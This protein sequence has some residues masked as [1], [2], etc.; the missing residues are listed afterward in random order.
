[1][2]RRVMKS[3]QCIQQASSDSTW[4]RLDWTGLNSTRRVVV[5]TVQSWLRRLT[6]GLTLVTAH[7]AARIVAHVQLWAGVRHRF[8]S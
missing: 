7:L 5:S 2:L 8:V 1:M 4:T 6:S 3:M